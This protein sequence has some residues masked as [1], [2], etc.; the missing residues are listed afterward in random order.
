MVCRP[1]L[2]QELTL[3]ETLVFTSFRIFVSAQ[4]VFQIIDPTDMIVCNFVLF[5]LELAFRLS[6]AHRDRFYARMLGCMSAMDVKHLFTQ[7]SNVK[8]RCD[9]LVTHAEFPTYVT[10]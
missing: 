2:W 7:R 5:G 9:N 4:S 3:L 1:F 6:V 10:S 8:F